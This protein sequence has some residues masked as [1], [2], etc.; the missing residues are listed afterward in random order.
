MCFVSFQLVRLIVASMYYVYIRDWFEI[1]PREQFYFIKSEEYF[2]SRSSVVPKLL[3]F[4]TIGKVPYK[5]Q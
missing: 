3:N 1:F 5:K 2:K 4:L